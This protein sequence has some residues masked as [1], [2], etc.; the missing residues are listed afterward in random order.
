MKE[1]PGE[2]VREQESLEHRLG[3]VVSA[4]VGQFTRSDPGS[5]KSMMVC[6]CVSMCVCAHA[7][8]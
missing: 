8:T 2:R 6:M 1:A 5:T 4:G 3:S 7:C